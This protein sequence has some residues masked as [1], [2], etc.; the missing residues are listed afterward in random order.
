[1]SNLNIVPEAESHRYLG[2]DAYDYQGNE[3]QNSKRY[4]NIRSGELDLNRLSGPQMSIPQNGKSQTVFG[5]KQSPGNR[6]N[7]ET[8]S[9]IRKDASKIILNSAQ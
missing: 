4:S 8:F 6:L 7:L 3:P 5:R 9:N 1:L 2:G